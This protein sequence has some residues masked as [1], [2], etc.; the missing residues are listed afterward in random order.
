MKNSR[1]CFTVNYG[2]TEI[3]LHLRMETR[4]KLAQCWYLPPAQ[5]NLSSQWMERAAFSYLRM[6]KL[7]SGTQLLFN[8]RKFLMSIWVLS[9]TSHVNSSPLLSER[10]FNL[11]GAAEQL[12][13]GGCENSKTENDNSRKASAGFSW[14][15]RAVI[16]T[17]AKPVV[18]RSVSQTQTHRSVV[19]F[20]VEFN[21]IVGG[22]WR[23]RIV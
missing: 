20:C 11:Y 13:I 23:L 21:S 1:F 2:E 19:P 10:N 9:R 12:V 14:P 15:Q 18:Y 5:H 16:A 3:N 6:S 8:H 17:A 7:R 4:K 22:S